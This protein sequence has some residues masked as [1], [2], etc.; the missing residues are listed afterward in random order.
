MRYELSYGYVFE[1]GGFEFVFRL[2]NAI[3][4]AVIAF[5]LSWIIISYIKFNQ[6]MKRLPE[7][8]RQMEEAKRVISEYH[9]L[10]PIE[11]IEFKGKTFRRG[12]PVRMIL[13]NKKTFVGNFVGGNSKNM[14]CIITPD[15][16]IT[17]EISC[18]EE[19]IPLD[20]QNPDLNH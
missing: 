4:A 9:N 12:M 20:S 1:I 10:Y 18:I 2:Q 16:I 6:L 11:K 19:L 13:R 3:I 17:Q 14:V 5:F 15:F 7:I 8:R